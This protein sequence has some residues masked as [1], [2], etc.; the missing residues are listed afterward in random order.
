MSERFFDEINATLLHYE[1]ESIYRLNIGEIT[2]ASIDPYVYDI[3]SE[4]CM[5]GEFD[6]Y[7]DLINDIINKLYRINYLMMIEVNADIIKYKL[8]QGKDFYFEPYGYM[9]DNEHK[10]KF[11]CDFVNDVIIVNR[12]RKTFF[13]SHLERNVTVNYSVGYDGCKMISYSVSVGNS[14]EN[15]TINQQ[16]KYNKLE[17]EEV[18]KQ[19]DNCLD[20]DIQFFYD[21]LLRKSGEYQTK[22]SKLSKDT[23]YI[24]ICSKHI[25]MSTNEKLIELVNGY[26]NAMIN[27]KNIEFEKTFNKNIYSTKYDIKL[28]CEYCGYYAA[29]HEK[30][31]GYQIDVFFLISK[32]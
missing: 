25:Y 12:L 10:S 27:E 22:L 11:I 26:I 23:Q 17:L 32:I 29:T 13:S 28:L 4:K 1:F 5:T 30:H 8:D 14:K 18:I 9:V 19:I 20:T 6:K 3:I 2:R 7:V 24:N 15:D 21:L 16:S 31:P